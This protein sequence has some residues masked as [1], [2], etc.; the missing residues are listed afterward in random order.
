LQGMVDQANSLM[1]QCKDK[2]SGTTDAEKTDSESSDT[3]DCSQLSSN[4]G[5]SGGG[6]IDV[7]SIIET[8]VKLLVAVAAIIASIIALIIAIQN[9]EYVAATAL[10]IAIV[11]Q[12]ESIANILIEAMEQMS[13]A[14]E[15]MG[16]STS[17]S[18]GSGSSGAG[19]GAGSGTS[20]GS[21]SGGSGGGTST[22]PNLLPVGDGKY[23]TSG[24]KKGYVYTCSKYAQS[25]QQ[26]KGGAN[27]R[28]P[29][30]VNN[31]SQYDPSKKP[32]V[33][34]S[35]SWKGFF[36]NAISG[37]KRTIKTNDVPGGH[38]TG[39]FPISTNDPAYSY[40]TNPNRIQEQSVTYSLNNNPAVGS[41]QCMGHE[42]GIM[43]SGVILFGALDERGRDAGAW[44]TQDSCEGHPKT[45]GV[46]HYHTLSSCIG[47]LDSKTV[48]GFALD[49]FPITGP[50]E[51]SGKVFVTN[52][53]D[54]CHGTTSDITL[55]GRNVNMYHYVMTKD[56]P[57]SVGCFRSTP[58][59][60]YSL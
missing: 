39:K 14:V 44:E 8:V 51:S 16:G 45:K 7:S 10:F 2:N 27:T 47:G 6:S 29:W 3:L 22:N 59:S 40:D 54:E 5:G 43:L 34:G 13:S 19:S 48:I 26:N 37:N 28:G 4:S 32:V 9:G 38:T 55:D 17:S 30:F 60:P 23:S 46:Y 33:Q 36:D 35:V 1:Q 42:A 20:S 49:G 53:L 18:S 25:F 15:G 21:N 57:Y 50:K 52:D 31:N 24:A 11:G 58:V 56:F 41:P 12:L